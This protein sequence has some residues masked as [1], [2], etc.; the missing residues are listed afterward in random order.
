MLL[1]LCLP[2]CCVLLFL[3]CSDSSAQYLGK[4]KVSELFEYSADGQKQVDNDPGISGG[5]IEFLKDKTVLVSGVAGVSKGSGRWTVLEDGRARIEIGHRRR[6]IM[7]GSIKGDTLTIT[8]IMSGRRG[9]G[10][11]KKIN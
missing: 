10:T 9:A 2:I 5:V 7:F 8:I 6:I 3:G 1:V 11:L 4:W